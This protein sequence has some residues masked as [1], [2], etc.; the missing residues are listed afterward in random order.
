MTDL[1][2]KDDHF[3]CYN[4]R[5]KEVVRTFSWFGM[6]LVHF[7]DSREEVAVFNR[8][9]HACSALLSRIKYPSS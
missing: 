4:K 8:T 3:V 7:L 2:S 6:E 1:I 5:T 9:N